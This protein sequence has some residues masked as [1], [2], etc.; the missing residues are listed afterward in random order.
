MYSKYESSVTYR[1]APLSCVLQHGW[2]YLVM[3]LQHPEF[4]RLMKAIRIGEENV[5]LRTACTRKEILKVQTKPLT[6]R[7]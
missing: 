7:H 2:F 1:I 6:S 3:V 4:E 5:A